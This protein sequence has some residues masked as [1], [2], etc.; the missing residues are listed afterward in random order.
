MNP[1]LIV[2]A[3]LAWAA[4]LWGFGAWRAEVGAT[5]ERVKWQAR[6]NVELKAAK[7][8]IKKLGEDARRIENARV[9]EM[10]IL[11][12]NYAKGFQDAEARRLR[13]IDDARAGA[14]RLRIPASACQG[15][16]G[17]PAAET[18]PTASGGNGPQ[19]VEL[20]A[21]VTEDLLTLANDADIVANQL[22]A[23]QEI[24]INDRR[25]P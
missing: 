24:I 13:D 7:D 22:R 16:G 15:T 6:E 18:G 11:A 20:P 5:G 10:T 23:C 8:A 19:T 17:S 9:D 4:S 21:K 3:L 12:I 25:A 1:W 2:A 14:L